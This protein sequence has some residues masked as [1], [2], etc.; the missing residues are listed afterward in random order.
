MKTKLRIPLLVLICLGIAAGA[1]FWATGLMDSIYAYR[2]PLQFSP[3][4]PGDALGQPLTRRVVVVLIDA[5]REDTAMDA[6]VMPH[7]AELRQQ[8]AWATMHSRP[9]SYSAPGYTV[10]FTGAW[11]ELSDG[12][13]LNLDYAEIPT[14]TQDNIFSAAERAGLKTAIS[15]YNWF[16]KLR[17]A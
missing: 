2:S 16:E 8:G 12:P 9:P 1:Y 10:L 6:S 15:A 17:H 4:Q 3:P 5:L 7:L 11:P 13:A 14:W